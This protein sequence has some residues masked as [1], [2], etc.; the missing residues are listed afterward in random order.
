MRPRWWSITSLTHPSHDLSPFSQPSLQTAAPYEAFLANKTKDTY[1]GT[2]SV[3]TF[4][5]SVLA[6]PLPYLYSKLM[7][8]AVATVLSPHTDKRQRELLSLANQLL[9]LDSFTLAAKCHSITEQV[10]MGLSQDRTPLPISS[11]HL[12]VAEKLASLAC[13]KFQRIILIR[14]MRKHRKKGK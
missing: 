5:V 2:M 8:G 13:S 9:Y 3:K 6:T 7:A 4:A 10:P 14:E 11:V 12:L 1:F